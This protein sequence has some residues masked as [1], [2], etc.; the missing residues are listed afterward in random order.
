MREEHTAYEESLRQIREVSYVTW[1]GFWVNVVIS[2]LKIVTGFLGN[3][4]AVVA[5]GVHSLSDLITDFAVLVGVRFWVAPADE[6]HPYGH[7]RLES[8]VTFIIGVVLGAAGLGIGYDAL[9]RMGEPRASGA[10]GSVAALGAALF[11]IFSKEWLYH[12]TL[13]KGRAIRSPAVEANAWHHRS[14][15]ISSIPTAVAV[16]LAMWLPSLAVVD[17]VAAIL[18]AGF[19]VKAAWDICKPAVET[20]LDKGADAR[21]CGRI[22]AFA[23]TVEGIQGIHS[24]RTRYLGS[25]LSID[26]HAAV[27]GNL[28]VRE[29]N[30]LAHSLEDAFYTPAAE[31]AIG[32]AVHDALVHIDPADAEPEPS[33]YS[34][35]AP[36][37]NGSTQ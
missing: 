6:A 32:I 31:Q 21:T 29:G 22:V 36:Q 28:T 19:I 3:S 20:L 7:Q 17:L 15:A 26:M 18:V 2:A 30:E 35:T 12:W 9:M 37:G 10:V 1:V 27:N 25:S 13:K 23:L 33:F 11:S 24:L 4:R 5:D 16:A 34:G 8:F 14:D